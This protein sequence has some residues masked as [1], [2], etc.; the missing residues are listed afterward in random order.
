MAVTQTQIEGL[1]KQVFMVD[2]LLNGLFPC[3]SD[4]VRLIRANKREWKFNDKFEYRMLLANTNTGGSLNSQV[5]NPNVQMN[6]P[7]SLEYGL[8]QATYGTVTD[9]MEV[10]M[11]A[12][13][14]TKDKAVAFNSDFATRMSSLRTNVASIFKNFAIHGKFGV[15]HQLRSTDDGGVAPTIS[16]AYNPQPNCGFT[17]VAATPF[18]IKVP[19]NVFNAN[20]KKGRLLI[21]TTKARPDGAA[22]VAELY[23]VLDNQPSRLTLLS[24]GTAI[25]EWKEGE[26]LELAYNREIANSSGTE[27]QKW[28]PAYKTG[29]YTGIVTVAS[30]PFAGEYLQFYA[31]GA[32]TDNKSTSG[33]IVGAMEGLAD[34]FPWYT[35]P[36]AP[37]TRLG[38]DTPFRGQAN[39]L[40]YSTEQAGSFV[41]QEE[42]E[43][44]MD[45]IMRAT[46]LTKATVPY[47][48]IGVW[49]NPIVKQAAAYEEDNNMRVVRYND[50]QG[51][52]YYQ[53]GV[54][55]TTYQIGSQTISE[56][57]EDL[58][59]PTDV[60]IIGPKNDLSYNC[61]DN[62]TFQIDDYIHETWGDN[63]PPKIEDLAIPDEVTASL[64][65]SN[66]ITYGAPTL[67]DGTR[68]AFTYG[69]GIRHPKNS[70]PMALHEMGAIFTE[71]PYC[72]T[73]VKLRKPIF[74]LGVNN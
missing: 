65:L 32:Y 10:D 33:A 71:Y 14:E 52:I 72:Y 21:K 4:T 27:F 22:D 41:L 17:P 55:S 58:N 5:Y 68:A 46:F 64:D 23:M 35:D 13:L 40:A 16:A 60:I 19:T 38:L 15:V 9:G 31:T 47:A 74:D 30:G 2:Y 66:R 11:T 20:F 1:A 67:T 57:I 37:E 44:I 7:G 18:T 51:P 49:M 26:F 73:V 45:T 25:S 50:Q 42:N 36:S 43:K 29:S 3:Q 59:L 12:N 48:D 62:A 6:R 34:L 8:F 69:N 70:M 54:R 61:W 39:R 53:R 24:V 56:V 63:P 28:G